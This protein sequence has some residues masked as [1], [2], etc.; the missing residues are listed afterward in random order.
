MSFNR[1]STQLVCEG[2]VGATCLN[3][4]SAR[5]PRL[6][7]YAL[8]ALD[9]VAVRQALLEDCSHLLFKGV[10][11]LVEAV[12]S[13]RGSLYSWAVVRLYYSCF[14]FLRAS[15]A[16]RGFAIVKNKSL[17]LLNAA[18]NAVA[19]KLTGN[20]YRNDHVGTISIYRD[21]FG[22]SD[23]LQSNMIDAQPSYE[24]LM[25]MRNRVNYRE[26]QFHDP[27]CPEFCTVA[28]ERVQQGQLDALLDT[29][30]DDTDFIYCF[31][32]DHAWLALPLK[33]AVLTLADAE[34]AAV[35]FQ[36]PAEKM[37][38]LDSL[39]GEPSRSARWVA[40]LLARFRT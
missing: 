8:T 22:A 29:Y 4:W 19:K 20:R 2:L 3:D 15:L 13:I 17:Y 39:L 24:W 38:L 25:E 1:L 37:A 27:G 18:P 33:R 35:S 6:E 7:S 9:A 5:R 11:T 26:R 16:A 23:I 34:A 12:A 32:S 31:Q 10:L 40:S 30:A 36:L 21:L 14:Y 28:S